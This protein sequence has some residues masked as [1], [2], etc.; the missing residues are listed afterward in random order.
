LARGVVG[1]GEMRGLFGASAM[2]ARTLLRG[3]LAFAAASLGTACVGSGISMLES[4]PR[5]AIT[6][7]LPQ[8]R[9]VS[10]NVLSSHLCEP[11]YYVHCKAEDL[12]PATRLAR[13]KAA[14][15]PHMDKEAVICL[16]EVS[17]QWAG[18]LTPFFESR[19]YTF[20]TGNYGQPFNG[21]MGVSLAWPR[22]RFESEA[23]DIQRVADVKPWVPPPA[24]PPPGPLVRGWRALSQ[25]WA[26]PKKR[27]DVQHEAKR[28]HNFLV[29]ARLRC[30]RSGHVVS[31]STYHMPCL[32]GSDPKVR[33]NGTER[34]GTERVPNAALMRRTC[35]AN[36]PLIRR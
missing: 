20:V 16:Q 4:A 32:F 21:Y 25:L 7:K 17:V 27:F 29:S 1:G 22:A 8:T 18:E 26:A 3:R 23:V 6:T 14:L 10:Y 9:V 15:T 11:D 36:Q 35:A 12:D 28:R 34:N 19:G 31:V 30:R 13:V 24:S 5:P 2:M 33:R